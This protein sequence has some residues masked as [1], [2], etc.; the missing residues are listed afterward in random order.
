[1]SILKNCTTHE[2]ANKIFDIFLENSKKCSLV[3][4]RLL[5]ILAEYY[6]VAKVC[7]PIFFTFNCPVYVVQ[8]FP[9]QSSHGFIEYSDLPDADGLDCCHRMDLQ[10]S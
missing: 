1:M 4:N 6:V 5:E 10:T 7:A 3:T 8:I 9:F 2:I